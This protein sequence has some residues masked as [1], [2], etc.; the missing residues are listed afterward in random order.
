MP[1]EL[2][3]CHVVVLLEQLLPLL[4]ALLG[5]KSGRS[6]NVGEQHGEKHPLI[7]LNR[8]NPRHKLLDFLDEPIL[9]VTPD[10]VVRAGQ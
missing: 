5:G 6:N 9:A 2:I 3:A 10:D 1:T 7:R 8:A 4:I